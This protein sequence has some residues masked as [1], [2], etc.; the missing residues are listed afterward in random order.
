[1]AKG[2]SGGSFRSAISG[3]FVTAKYGK[4]SSRTTVFERSGGGSTGG[5]YRSAIN[6][7]FVTTAH[8]KR[9]PNTSIKD[10]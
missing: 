10:N 7:R 3:R 4:A 6:G 5:A 2:R 9:S 1:M 8:G